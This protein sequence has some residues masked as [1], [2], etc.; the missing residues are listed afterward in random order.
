[1]NADEQE[2]QADEN[3]DYKYCGTKQ[4]RSSAG[5]KFTSESLLAKIV[6]PSKQLK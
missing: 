6:E 3:R 1:V 2:Y 4:E 5:V